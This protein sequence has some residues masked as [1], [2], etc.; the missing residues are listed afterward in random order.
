VSA[1][2]FGREPSRPLPRD[3]DSE[4]SSEIDLTEGRSGSERDRDDPTEPMTI[5]PDEGESDEPD[6]AEPTAG[7]SDVSEGD[8]TDEREPDAAAGSD[9]S[10]GD[11][12]GEREPDAAAGSD[13]SEGDETGERE[14]DAAAESDAS[15]GDEAGQPRVPEGFEAA[16]PEA[17]APEVPVGFKLAEA[18]EAAN[19]GADKTEPSGYPTTGDTDTATES[20]PVGAEVVPVVVE[21]EGVSA[22]PEHEPAGLD[23]SEMWIEVQ[24]QFVDDPPAATAEALRMLR[25][26]LDGL[27]PA[28]ASTEDLRVAFRRY[29]AAYFDLAEN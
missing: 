23:A 7:G 15:E 26:R 3:D 28:G 19:P 11:E 20:P 2:V 16:K 9:V 22:E 18:F 10:E 24:A 6:A 5:E 29:R 12:T 25:E 14:P 1:P 13:V 27:A 21:A 8:E 17:D 4:P